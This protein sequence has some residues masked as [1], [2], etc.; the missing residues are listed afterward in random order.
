VL[1]AILAVTTLRHVP[2]TGT[3]PAADADDT[4]DAHAVVG[5]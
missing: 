1:L 3:A 4:A 2:P 5:G